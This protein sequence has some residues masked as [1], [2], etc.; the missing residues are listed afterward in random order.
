MQIH[1]CICCGPTNPSCRFADA[2]DEDTQDTASSSG[3]E[4][5]EMGPQ[6]QRAPARKPRAAATGE[7]D[8]ITSSQPTAPASVA[9]SFGSRPYLTPDLTAV[10]CWDVI[11]GLLTAV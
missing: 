8:S 5:P 3:S 7:E 9:F 10:Q 4:G 1:P 2:S 6:H 11:N